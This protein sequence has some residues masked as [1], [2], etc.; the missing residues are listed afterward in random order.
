M[1]LLHTLGILQCQRDKYTLLVGLTSY[2]ETVKFLLFHPLFSVVPSVFHADVIFL[3]S[4]MPP[5]TFFSLTVLYR[6]FFFSLTV[7][8]R[9]LVCPTHYSHLPPTHTQVGEVLYHLLWNHWPLCGCI[10]SLHPVPSALLQMW[11]IVQ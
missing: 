10:F 3:L 5:D 11:F 6:S 7:P 8:Y 2:K 9:S 1:N 4:V